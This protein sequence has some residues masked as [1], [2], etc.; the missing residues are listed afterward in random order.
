VPV[1]VHFGDFL[2]VVVPFVLFC[3]E[4]EDLFLVHLEDVLEILEFFMTPCSIYKHLYITDSYSVHMTHFTINEEYEIVLQLLKKQS[5]GRAL[6]KELNIPLTTVQ[7]RVNSLIGEGV[8]EYETEGKNKILS[9]KNNSLAEAKIIM[10]EQYKLLKLY[11]K[12]PDL[13]ILFEQA[14]DQFKGM[15]IL[16][17]SY[18]KFSA[19]KDSDIDVYIQ[20]KDKKLK[21]KIQQINSK[22]SIQ[23]GQLSK[24]DPLSREIFNNHCIIRGVEEYY[25]RFYP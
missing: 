3:D 11:S 2:V 20:T 24:T 19:K 12:Y 1:D 4:V 22:L 5:H 6:A 16:F 17:G 14:T 25:D 23:I 15:I 7:N 10:A 13:R 18:A 8:I 9:L 21:E